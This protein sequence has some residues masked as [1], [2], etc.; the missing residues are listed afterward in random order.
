MLMFST[1]L[2]SQATYL[3]FMGHLK[4][5]YPFKAYM[6]SLDSVREELLKLR[7]SGTRFKDCKQRNVVGETSCQMSVCR[8]GE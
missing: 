4:H 5:Y 8:V 1:K 6:Y 3:D 2:N 7:I